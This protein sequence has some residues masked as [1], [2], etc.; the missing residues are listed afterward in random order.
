MRCAVQKRMWE[1][2]F[3]SGFP[4]SGRRVCDDYG[5]S[6]LSCANMGRFGWAHGTW[7]FVMHDLTVG[8]FIAPY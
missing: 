5:L 6:V 8:A 7:L 4:G 2:S 3:G 1:M